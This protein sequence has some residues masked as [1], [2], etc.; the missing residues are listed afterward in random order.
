MVATLGA[1]L[2]DLEADVRAASIDGHAPG[3]ALPP[4]GS[5]P[6]GSPDDEPE[7]TQ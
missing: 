3:S 4:D 7:R 2:D 6:A 5:A 1:R